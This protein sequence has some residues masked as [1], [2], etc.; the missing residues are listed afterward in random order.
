MSTSTRMRTSTSTRTQT[1]VYLT[2]VITGAFSQIVASLGLSAG[3]LQNNWTTIETGLMTW[4]EEGTLTKVSLEFG[5]SSNPVA[6]VEIP[7]QY[8]YSGTG[9]AEFVANR[10]RLARQMA[11]IQQ[12]PVGTNYRVVVNRSGHYTDVPGWH[13]TTAASRDGLTSYNLGSLGYGPDASLSMN[14]LYRST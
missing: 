8:R 10:A 6:I 12:I 11:K 9:D 5:D 3:H 2:D 1:A 14:Y 4:I 13:A 7:L